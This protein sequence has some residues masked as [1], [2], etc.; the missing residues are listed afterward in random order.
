M[1]KNNC[2]KWL[3]A[4]TSVLGATTIV[5]A[6]LF[7][8]KSVVSNGGQNKFTVT[9]DLGNGT[10]VKEEYKM[11][12][13]PS[14][15]GEKPSKSDDTE[16]DKD[17]MKYHYTF[18]G[19]EETISPVAKDVTYHTHYIKETLFTVIK[20]YI[21]QQDIDVNDSTYHID[22]LWDSEEE[23]AW[24]VDW[25][26]GDMS[27]DHDQHDH[28]YSTPGIKTIK[29]HNK[30]TSIHFNCDDPEQ[31][32]FSKKFLKEV[33]IPYGVEK[34]PSSLE[35]NE[36]AMFDATKINKITFPSSLVSLT[37]VFCNN[38]DVVDPAEIGEIILP[39]NLKVIEKNAFTGLGN[40]KF[41]VTVPNTVNEVQEK[42]FSEAEISRLVLPKTIET[43]PEQSLQLL[44]KFHIIDMTDYDT[45]PEIVEDTFKTD[46]EGLRK[47]L[48]KDTAYQSFLTKW[49][50]LAS[51]EILKNY[52]FVV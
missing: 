21:S 9:W 13:M 52:I 5:F 14:Y 1:E 47:I 20:G 25:G 4:S 12:E 40:Y 26:D 15:K 46:P 37:N 11:G 28:T 51:F 43:Y 50:S 27:I 39:T 49:S 30:C 31:Y 32:A 48:V 8:W 22:E 3:I 33:T 16:Y 19:W 36:T 45:A 23:A 10:T 42:A 2:K 44:G 34:L 29:I 7:I 18:D 17:R 35:T 6:S 41:P 24:D 38:G